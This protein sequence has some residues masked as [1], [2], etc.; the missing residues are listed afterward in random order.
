MRV[1][2]R[3]VLW[4]RRKEIVIV[5]KG[6]RI[7]AV[8]AAAGVAAACCQ[9]S[10]FGADGTGMSFSGVSNGLVRLDF[11][12]GKERRNIID[13]GCRLGRIVVKGEAGGASFSLDTGN[14]FGE[15]A[16]DAQEHRVRR[17]RTEVGLELE[18][19]FFRDGAEAVWSIRLSNASPAALAVTDL[20]LWMPLGNV[21]RKIQARH[22]LNR[23]DAI[24]GYGSWM[25]WV[26]YDGRGECVV[27]LPAGNTPLE[28]FT[29]GD[30]FYVHSSTVRDPEGT[31]RIPATKLELAPGASETY[32]FRFFAVKEH[33][34]VPDAILAHGGV[35]VRVVPSMTIPRGERVL[36]A[37]RR[38]GEVG[39]VA[40]EHP[41]TTEVGAWRAAAEG[42]KVAEATFGRLGENRLAVEIGGGRLMYLDFFVTEDL[43]TVVKKRAAFIVRRQQHRNPEKWYDGLY[44][45]FDFRLGRLLSP[46]YLGNIRERYMVGGSDDPSNCKPLYISEKNA[47]YPDA[48]EIASL[49]YYERNF[50]WG[51]LQRTDK[52]FPH[53]C[54]IYGSD[55][56]HENRSGK[57]GGYLSGGCG[58]E[59]MWRTFDYVTHIATYFNLYR[60][61]R[62]NPSLTH[63]LDANGYLERAY[64]TAMAYFKVPYNI[65]MGS[66]W[67]F[68]GWCDW[69]YK[70]GNFHERY[71]LDL[72][73]ALEA[74]GLQEKA[75]RLR[76]EWEKKVTYMTYEDPWPYGSEMFVDRTAF[77]S[78]YYVA[79]YALT[80]R[81]V[82]QEKLWYDKNARRWYT[83]TTYQEGP[84]LAAMENQLVANLALRGLNGT[85][86][87]RCGT[88]WSGVPCGSLDYMTQMGGVALLDYA[89]RFAQ[90]GR[91]CELLRHGYNSLLASW[92]L[93]NCGDAAAGHGYWRK[94][95]EF[96]GAAGWCFQSYSKGHPYM[97]YV[98]YARGPWDIDSEIDHGFT[99]GIHGAGCYVADDPVFGEVAY[100]GRLESDES[101]WRV[102]PW[103]GV[104]RHVAI[105]QRGRLE[106]RLS[107][108][109]FARGRAVVVSKDLSS[110]VLPLE[111]RGETDSQAVEFRGLDEGDWIVRTKGNADVRF[112]SSGSPVKVSFPWSEEA[113]VIRA[114]A[115][116]TR[117][118]GGTVAR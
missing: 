38:R 93:V 111:R 47:A 20:G 12:L 10:A 75:D 101:E 14:D 86:Y 67:A 4:K 107:N 80:R 99:G 73:D 115:P 114:N 46:E 43:E 3:S 32:S 24:C 87:N 76:R 77:E 21:T 110:M 105:P 19:S 54:G 90:P 9:L 56:W 60:I 82:P 55:N 35:N 61:A 36:F 88:A 42:F 11:T 2:I 74:N 8:A 102:T 97:R 106:I 58:R 23:H 112:H 48:D 109:G 79:E 27:M 65:E 71:I 6:F 69:A 78:S 95:A 7:L 41:D 40:A 59:R 66:R 1:K 13:E 5:K 72:L 45:L 18:E 117:S 25:Y 89:V 49:E 68:R 37:V 29:E 63:Y 30:W 52:E 96:D 33:A 64:L 113:H 104:R 85:C 26:P 31:W 53:P 98:R 91:Q 28:Y 118:Q 100:G 15:T 16:V 34:A 108:N 22:N 50:V 92:A 70:Q 17:W 62:E 51:K 81:M 94:G 44:S 103:D 39:T 116:S 57:C 84:K 83:Y